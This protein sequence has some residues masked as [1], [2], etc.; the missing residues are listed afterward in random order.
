MYVETN[1]EFNSV[2]QGLFYSGSITNDNLKFYFVYDCGSSSKDIYLKS[3]VERIREKIKSKFKCI[4]LLVISHFD[5]DHVNGIDRLLTEIGVNTVII[6]YIIPLHRLAIA[7]KYPNE[8]PSYYS[9][10]SNPI[11]FLTDRGVKNIILL[12]NGFSSKEEILDFNPDIDSHND[13]ELIINKLFNDKILAKRL[14]EDDDYE[15]DILDNNRVQI[16][17]HQGYLLLKN[18]WIF[19]F[20]NYKVDE[21]IILDFKKSL[22]YNGI[23]ISSIDKIRELIMKINDKN[24]KTMKKIKKC[25]KKICGDINN[26]S[27]IMYHGPIGNPIEQHEINCN[28]KYIYHYRYGIKNFYIKKILKTYYDMYYDMYYEM[29]DGMYYDMFDEMFYDMFDEMYYEMHYDKFDDMDYEMFNE[30][31]NKMFDKKRLIIRSNLYGTMLL[32]DINLNTNLNQIAEHF[33]ESLKRTQFILV[34][35]HASKKSWNR[36]LFNY[37]DIKSIWIYG[38]GVGRKKHP[39]SSVISCFEKSR[40]RKLLLWNNEYNRIKIY[41]IYKWK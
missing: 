12:S 2:G 13:D 14:K 6:P 24:K 16:K 3:E 11:K 8:E 9:F 18:F 41:S 22:I 31:F 27:V 30:M 35:H 20:F 23:D 29:F 38:A 40:P 15:E 25:Y 32:G 17:S 21:K 36:D 7:I 10:M 39:N 28:Y 1:F 37:V 5:A 26:T 33:K 4:N 19:K 34:P